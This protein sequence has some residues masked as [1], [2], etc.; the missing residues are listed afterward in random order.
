MNISED[1]GKDGHRKTGPCDVRET[2]GVTA[3]RT[4]LDK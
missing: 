1:G 4:Q 2:V 3:E